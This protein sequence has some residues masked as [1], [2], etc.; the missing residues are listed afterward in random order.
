MTG[1]MREDIKGK[2]VIYR[3][4]ELTDFQKK[5]NAAAAEI[6][7]RDSTLVCKCNRGLL[8]D[9]ARQQYF[10]TKQDSKCQVKDMFLEKGSL[11]PNFTV[12][13]VLLLQKES[14]SQKPFA[15]KE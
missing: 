3:S 15:P 8:P 4:S 5:I 10:Q 12:S 11:V 7:L 6:A 9:Q 13:L 2:S 14:R 1:K